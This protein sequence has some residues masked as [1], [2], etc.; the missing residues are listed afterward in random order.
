MS[1]NQPPPGP[2]G[3]A[4]QQGPYG[5]PPGPYGAQGAPSPYG[6]PPQGGYPPP[7]QQ[8]GPYGQPPQPGYGQQP[9]GHPGFPAPPQPPGRGGR[10]A[11]AVIAAA[12]TLVVIVGGAAYLIGSG[13]EEGGGDGKR[14]SAGGGEEPTAKPVKYRLTTPATLAGDWTQD[15]SKSG[16]KSLG[17]S[18]VEH[19]EE[20]GVSADGTVGAHYKDGTKAAPRQLQFS[21]VY[22]TV[23]DP[24]RA[25]DGAFEKLTADSAGESSDGAK[26][27]P[28]GAPQS[29]RPAGLEEG[30]VLKC[31]S[32]RF[33]K[34]SDSGKELSFEFPS[35][36]W[37][38]ASTVGYTAVSDPAALFNGRTMEL[39]E[40]ADLTARVRSEA[41]QEQAVAG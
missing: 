38:D 20:L 19:L 27:E 34:T 32:V 40:A 22:G 1:Y 41:R 26:A 7:G 10:T 6:Q 18:E 33:T 17:T 5:S 36:V 25:V 16:G 9:Y 12:V 15:T 21:G 14:T 23:T 35:C 30:A 28:V 2:Y 29:F 24:G 39:S 8:P 11:A 4:G 13:G 31:V 37:G 3:G